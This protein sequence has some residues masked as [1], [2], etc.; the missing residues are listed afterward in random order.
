M[1]EFNC[2]TL[3]YCTPMTIRAVCYLMGFSWLKATHK[4]RAVSG[5]VAMSQA[6]LSSRGGEP[7]KSEIDGVF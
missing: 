5:V 1:F 7:I 6:A 4:E 3:L 2:L